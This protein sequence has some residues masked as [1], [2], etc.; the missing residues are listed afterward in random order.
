MLQAERTEE[1]LLGH[2]ERFEIGG[3]VGRQF[4]DAVIEARQR[5]AALVVVHRGEDMRQDADRVLRRTTKHAGMQVAIRRGDGYVLINETAQRR[6][7]RRRL[8]VPHRRVADQREVELELVGI[9]AH[10]TIEVL[11][12]A[13]L[14]ALDHGGDRHR[15]RAGDVLERAARLDEGHRL[16]LIVAGAARDDDLAAV[17][18]GIDAR[19][20]RR[21][22][23][24]V[25]RIDRLHVIMPV[26]QHVW[27]LGRTALDL[28]DNHRMPVGRAHLGGETDAPQIGRDVLGRLPAVVLVGGIGRDRR[29]PQQREQS[30]NTVV[31]I[32]VDPVQHGVERAHQS[33]PC[34]APSN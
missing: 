18:Q 29:D 23:P 14:L 30:L 19:L 24:E 31:D 28:A 7:H 17:R 13:F 15:Q 32:G 34:D 9:V 20:E 6:R 8:L 27:G 16:T 22:F 1:R 12:A 21:R 5:D 4:V 11:R 2:V 25:E 26:K 3:D 10:E 33:S